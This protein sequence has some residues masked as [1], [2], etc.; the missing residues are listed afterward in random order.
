V[1]QITDNPGYYGGR[2]LHRTRFLLPCLLVVLVWRRWKT[3]GLILVGAAMT[4]IVPYLLIGDATRF[5]LPAAFAYLILGSIATAVVQRQAL[6][7]VA[8]R[9]LNWRPGP[10]TP[11]G[12]RLAV[13]RAKTC[14]L[15]GQ[16]RHRRSRG[17]MNK[18]KRRTAG[19]LSPFPA[20]VESGLVDVGSVCDGEV[21][22]S[23]ASAMSS[24]RLISGGYREERRGL[25]PTHR[26]VGR[27]GQYSS[28]LR[29]SK[30]N[31]A[32]HS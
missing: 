14:G 21:L 25:S 19:T 9:S 32:T 11:R 10:A 1:R 24:N 12:T 6:V 31:Q 30:A 4:T 13:H 29:R 5:Y 17:T 22:R 26:K 3:A 20:S 18:V 2:I 27:M 23:I 7:T 16:E 28:H 15:H 8:D